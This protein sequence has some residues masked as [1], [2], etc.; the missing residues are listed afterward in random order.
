MQVRKSLLLVL[1]VLGVG[2]LAAGCQSEQGS[3]IGV[4]DIN[5]IVKESPLAKGYQQQLVDKLEELESRIKEETEG[6]EADAKE[7]KEKELYTEYL[8]LKE[9]LEGKL[10]NEINKALKEVVKER[11][12][13]V[14]L[15]QEAV[16]FGGV[17]VS[18]DVI[19]R[20]K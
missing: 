7:E 5:K 4:I 12:L 19:K 13:T 10:E 17:D 11:N 16:R 8:R 3:N 2:L 14:V 9:E 18:D 6:L 1:A 15:Y 20:L